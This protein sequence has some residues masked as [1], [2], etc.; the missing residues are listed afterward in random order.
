MTIQ[1]IV[2]A[3][4]LFL[5]T[6]S[7]L[8]AQQQDAPAPLHRSIVVEPGVRLS[9]ADWG[10]KGA[11][12]LFV[13]SWTGTEHL[14][15]DFAPRFTDTFRVL[16][17]NK[18]GHGAST[19]PS[20]GY[21]IDRLTQDMLAVLDSL[22]VERATV[23]ALSR[24]ASLVTQFAARYPARVDNLVYLSGPIDRAHARTNP[25][26]RF[27]GRIEELIEVLGN[28]CGQGPSPLHPA[29]SFD[30][31][32]DTLGVAWRQEDPPPPY[33]R[34]TAPALA[35]WSATNIHQSL[36]RQCGRPLETM[37]SPEIIELYRPIWEHR[38][39][40]QTHDV[41]LF[42]EELGGRVVEISGA[43][44]YTYLTHPALVESEIRSFL[45]SR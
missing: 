7:A 32:A 5:L 43:A 25:R 23:L 9:I 10:G 17:M 11:T 6:P 3:A 24:S 41:R 35:F 38:V 1:R 22:G 19:R 4:G 28:D 16:V 27:S 45:R 34:V 15:D 30:A 20:H 18:R 14:F 8:A 33:G 2:V 13:P 31:S 44:Y 36:A 12:L 40:N 29:G 21:S 42:E 37:W 26:P 39:V